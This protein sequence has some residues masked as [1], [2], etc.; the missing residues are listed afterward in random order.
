MNYNDDSIYIKSSSAKIFNFFSSFLCVSDI[1]IVTSLL[2]SH[3][4]ITQQCGGS[5]HLHAAIYLH[6]NE[7]VH[8]S[9]LLTIQLN[10]VKL[11]EKE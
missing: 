5:K 9:N 6:A 4:F 7:S 3:T 2:P 11:I 8:I 10:N 1:N